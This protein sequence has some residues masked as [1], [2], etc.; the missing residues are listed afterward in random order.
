MYGNASLSWC[1][2]QN[3]WD[4]LKMSKVS[5][6]WSFIQKYRARCA[7][8]FKKKKKKKMPRLGTWQPFFCIRHCHEY[9]STAL[10]QINLEK[11]N[12]YTLEAHTCTMVRFM[13]PTEGEGDIL[14]LVRILLAS[15][16]ASASASASESASASAS[17]WHFLVCTISH[18]PVG[19][20]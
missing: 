3:A 11:A 19:G 8:T 17:A 6:R 4:F 9:D 15:A 7:T 20:F 14:F 12:K 2:S 1:F 13:S 5:A 18:E 10:Y 16:L